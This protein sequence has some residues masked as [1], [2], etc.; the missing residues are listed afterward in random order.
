MATRT[1]CEH[2]EECG[3]VKWRTEKPDGHMTPLPENGDCGKK[4]E[5][6]GRLNPNVP[7]DIS[8]YGPKFHSELELG[9]P[10]IP[11]R[12]NRPR[13]RLVGGGHR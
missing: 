13:R 10:E 12:N 6:C 8:A 9:F 2:Y 1:E 3:F 4:I 5:E 11:N 7:T